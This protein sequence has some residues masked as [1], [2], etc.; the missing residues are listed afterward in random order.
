MYQLWSKPHSD[1]PAG[2]VQPENAALQLLGTFE[3][4]SLA[5]RR[6]IEI[7][8]YTEPGLPLMVFF[9]TEFMNDADAVSH[10]S[11]NSMTRRY[12]IRTKDPNPRKDPV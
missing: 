12:F 2:Q 9:H 4:I 10:Y 5:A 7:E 1:L 8:G 6:I 11:F 3:S